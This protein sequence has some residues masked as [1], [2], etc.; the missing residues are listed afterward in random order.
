M[1]IN[2]AT[3]FNDVS[4]NWAQTASS[5]ANP[6]DTVLDSDKRIEKLCQIALET[7]KFEIELYWKRTTYYWAFIAADLAAFALVYNRKCAGFATFL[8][9]RFLRCAE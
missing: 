1:P 5:A 9:W 4:S 3:I 6:A 8:S 7:R 2:F